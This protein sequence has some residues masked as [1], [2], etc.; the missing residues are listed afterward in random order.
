MKNITTLTYWKTVLILST[1]VIFLNIDRI[2]L[3]EKGTFRRLDTVDHYSTKLLQ[4]NRYIY[5][6]KNYAWDSSYL[7]GWPTHL[8]SLSPNHLGCHLTSVVPLA[9]VFI[10]IKIIT[11]I[12]VILGGFFLFYHFFELTLIQSIFGAL[13]NLLTFYWFYENLFVIQFIALPFLLGILANSRQIKFFP[14]IRFGGMILIPLLT[15]PPYVVPI[16]PIFHFATLFFSSSKQNR[17][18]YFWRGLIFWG[19]FALFFS[20]LII[21]YAK[22]F[23]LSNRA[24][25]HLAPT[26]FNIS[27]GILGLFTTPLIPFPHWPLLAL[28]TGLLTSKKYLKQLL[29]V[30]GLLSLITFSIN[31]DLSSWLS[32]YL[33]SMHKLSFFYAR[34]PYITPLFLLIFAGILVKNTSPQ[35]LRFFK[36]PTLFTIILSI[37]YSLVFSPDRSILFAL[38]VF[39]LIILYNFLIYKTEISIK[40]LFTIVMLFVP[41]R[42]LHTISAE[43]PFFGG[44]FLEKNRF[45][46]KTDLPYRIGT[47]TT[48]CA[49]HQIYLAQTA[50]QGKEE[51]GGVAVFYDLNI[52]KDWHEHLSKNSTGCARDFYLWNN[53]AELNYEFFIKNP[54]QTINWLQLNNVKFLRSTVQLPPQKE[55]TQVAEYSL[56]SIRWRALLPSYKKTNDIFWYSINPTIGRVFALKDDPNLNV[57]TIEL[58][59]TF[60]VPITQYQSSYIK[61]HWNGKSAETIM[62]SNNYHP[63][64]KLYVDG[65]LIQHGINKGPSNYL[66]F[67]PHLGI[68]TYEIIFSNNSLTIQLLC[69]ASAIL[70]FFLFSIFLHDPISPN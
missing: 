6:N 39:T 53:R 42:I 21:G 3:G 37:C 40:I 16:M 70:F 54:Q 51:I 66:Q 7:R 52:V 12:I 32:Q 64:W 11:E 57:E 45:T 15:F 55:L 36:L 20:P 29:V 61:F 28:I 68:H 46:P 23:A 1:L 41:I 48:S 47:V 5:D 63:D 19:I 24:F 60:S 62:V 31:S 2:L 14:I 9:Y 56:P 13:F 65:N 43:S 44:L 67:S 30:L 17:T 27:N 59:T 4:C 18:T 49:P 33:S 34:L 8:G 25:F 69:A 22:S 35:N 26:R 38:N 58:A 50:I 10:I